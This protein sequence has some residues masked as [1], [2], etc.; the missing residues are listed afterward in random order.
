MNLI[1]NLSLL[2]VAVIIAAIGILGFSIYF[3]NRRS[4][5]NKSFLAFAIITI[6]Y[7]SLNYA[8][9]IVSS[10]DISFALLKITI[11]L[12]LWHAFYFMQLFYVFP[13]E[14]I[15]FPFF[16]RYILQ[17]ITLIIGLLTLTPFIFSGVNEV[18]TTGKI[19]TVNNGPAIALFGL[20]I[21]VFI[22]TGLYYLI[23]KTIKST[24]NERTQFKF[25]SIG[26]FITFSF[27]VIFNLLLPLY[28]Q[29][30]SFTS[31]AAIFFFPFISFTAYAI[32]KHKLFNLKIAGTV[33]LTF[34][35]TIVSFIEIIFAETVTITIFR[36][37]VFFLVMLFSILII[38]GVL[39]EIQQRER[40]EVLASDLE[41]SNTG[42]AEANERL[43]D[44]D[45]M[46]TEFISL[47]THQIRGPLTAIKGYISLIQE[48][49]YGPVSKEV[50]GAVDVVMN[51][52]NNLV[53]IVGDFLDVSRIEQ[54]RMKYDF[55]DFDLQE[56]VNQVIVEF[57]PT[58]DKKGLAFNYMFDKDKSYMIH[59]DRGKIKQVFGNI[60]DNSIKYTPSGGIDISLGV[61]DKKALIAIKDTGVGIHKST[62][63]KLFQKF[64]R[65]ENANETNIMG[66]GLG[67]Y[68][69]KQMIEAHHGRVWAES[70]GEE[71]GAQFYIELGTSDMKKE[72]VPVDQKPKGILIKTH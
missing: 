37:V 13:N 41:K 66:T 27:L 28:F 19:L 24:G 10:I 40:I 35:L 22:S 23:K 18:S 65:A 71:K 6:L 53:T 58:M 56:L 64:T 44:L 50:L 55:T 12:A 57:K 48:G 32:L 3:N 21:I 43:K 25:I 68:V 4:I 69:A 61:K 63:P 11:F 20:A 72:D 26:V 52:T 30:S 67:L 62:L 59:A 31:F 38:K 36:I 51:S 34:A 29:N 2:S 49:D 33:S 60:L 45:K 16:Y 47:A 70:E 8:R 7:S 15:K 39:R 14:N 46:K 5:T 1:S 42:L 9:D 17:P 54:G